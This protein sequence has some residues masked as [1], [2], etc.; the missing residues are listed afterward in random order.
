M[1]K[2]HGKR[3]GSG[4]GTCFAPAERATSDE[5]RVQRQAVTT[6]GLGLE[7][8]DA[9][10]D[11]F[12]ILN[13]QRQ[14]VYANRTLLDLLGLQTECALGR[15]PGE[16]LGCI[17]SCLSEG[18]CGTSEYC[19]TCG[20]VRAILQAQQGKRAVEECRIT[21]QV[22]GEALDLRV[23]ATPLEL[24]GQHYTLFAVVDISNEKRRRALERIFFHDLL[25]TAGG[26]LGF[27]ELLK[28]AHDDDL[29]VYRGI[30]HRLA[31]RLIDEIKA[32]RQL[33]AAET[34]ELAVSHDCLTTGDLL[35]DL[36]Q[37]YRHHEVAANRKVVIAPTSEDVILE[38]DASLLQ[39][40]LGNMV[41]NAL[42]ASAPGETVTLCCR[43]DGRTAE[44][45]VHNPGVMADD[46]QLQVFQRS[47][48]T[49]GTARGLGTYSMR[50]LGERYLGGKVS[51]SSDV[52]S[53]TTFSIRLPLRPAVAAAGAAGAARRAHA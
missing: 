21:R 46:V 52:S 28:G 41:K 43:A 13:G 53:G 2:A 11:V 15:R 45:S 10:P 36:A 42:E 3:T 24:A 48:S 8:L 29:E 47:F 5:V 32:Q 50:L 40:V 19:R 9:I 12:M 26:L 38:S 18:G 20:A 30:L 4:G 27:T 22:D 25:N 39:R 23:W 16:L 33:A 34:G 49:K 6:Q 31:E 17:H 1:T 37:L 14:V 44:L 51:F 7:L 35:R